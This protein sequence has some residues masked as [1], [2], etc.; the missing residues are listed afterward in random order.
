MDEE[1]DDDD[2]GS[3]LVFFSL[4]DFCSCISFGSFFFF[5]VFCCCFLLCLVD[6][7]SLFACY[8]VYS[9]QILSLTMY[10]DNNTTS[11]THFFFFFYIYLYLADKFVVAFENCKLLRKKNGFDHFSLFKKILLYK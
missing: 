9:F 7:S 2:D 6:E 1:E 5:D 4:V 3:D 10:P 8:L 11:N